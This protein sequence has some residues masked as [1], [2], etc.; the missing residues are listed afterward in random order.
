MN[1]IK[2]VGKNII[3]KTPNVGSV[4]TPFKLLDNAV[5]G[6]L[7]ECNK[8]PGNSKFKYNLCQVN[9]CKERTNVR[10]GFPSEICENV[11]GT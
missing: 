6:Y 3:D 8:S 5:T 9:C 4:S 10:Q 2:I 11:R 7:N 1:K